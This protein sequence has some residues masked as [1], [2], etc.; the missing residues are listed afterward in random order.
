MTSASTDGMV[1]TIAKSVARS[2]SL[3]SACFTVTA[4]LFFNGKDVVG[5]GIMILKTH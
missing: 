4:L 1:G 3:V 2:V 5:T